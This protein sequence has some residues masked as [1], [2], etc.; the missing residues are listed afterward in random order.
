ME[1][2][3]AVEQICTFRDDLLEDM[4]KAIKTPGN[5]H[6]AELRRET[7]KRANKDQLCLWVETLVLA[8]SAT[9]MPLLTEV[10]EDAKCVEDMKKVK[11]DDQATIIDL[12]K[13]LIDAKDSQIEKLQESVKSSVKCVEDKVKTFSSVLQ[14]EM[15]TQ[16]ID[17][18]KSVADVQKSVSSAF[19]TKKVGDAVKHAVEKDE[20]GKNVVIFGVPEDI[21]QTLETCVGGVLE[22]LGQ[23]PRIVDCCRLGK[24]QEGAV[25]PVKVTLSNSSVATELLR[26]SKVLKD[27]EECRQIFICPDR[28]VE[29]RKVQKGLIDQL[30]KKRTEHPGAR[31][32]IRNGRVVLSENSPP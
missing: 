21:T 18:Q 24:E 15:E 14:K 1:K 26:K 25:R 28:T 16:R 8:F 11:V 27:V 7:L 32:S 30:K 10:F 13:K 5:D 9:A 17:V 22:H 20:R 2:N 23:K 12:Q 4:G 3:I 31:Y 29:Q 19:N 6:H